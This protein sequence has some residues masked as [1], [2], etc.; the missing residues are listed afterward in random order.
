[1]ATESS[2]IIFNI[3]HAP[4]PKSFMVTIPMNMYRIK[5]YAFEPGLDFFQRSVLKLKANPRVTNTKIAECLGLDEELV[6]QIVRVLQY[7]NYVDSNGFLTQKG[8]ET[9]KNIDGLAIN[10]QE[11]QLGY[12]FQYIDRDDY[13]PYYIKDLGEAPNM[14]ND[15]D[16]IIGTKGDGRD[17]VRTP[18]PIDSMEKARRVLPFPNENVIIDLIMKS[19]HKDDIFEKKSARQMVESLSLSY[20]HETPEP[21]PVLFCTY[22]YLP[23]RDEDNLYEP[24]WQILDP[25]GHDDSS[26]L[27]FYIE[28]LNDPILNKEI[29]RK[30]HDAETLARKN[31]G[32]YNAFLTNEL[33]KMKEND[34]GIEFRALDRNLQQYLDSAIKNMFLFRQ[35]NY[36]DFDS[37]DM[38][39]IST[40]RALETLFRLDSERRPDVYEEMKDE[41]ST[42]EGGNREEYY[43][44]RRS[45]LND[46]IRN[47]LISIT[48]PGRLIGLSKKVEPNRANSLK[49]YIYSL[50]LTYN[51]DNHSPLFKLIDG[52]IEKLFDIAQLRNTKGHGQTEN[53]GTVQMVTKEV[54]EDTYTFLQD[55]INT[56]MHIAL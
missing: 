8:I 1:M 2:R 38:F 29:D 52:R 17:N 4:S 19:C 13:Y 5:T 45:F 35:Y 22:I 56:Y 46:L 36:H 48:D 47:R 53:E 20:F 31:F 43:R 49:Q 50:I 25:F 11:E 16:I 15:T 21:I 3:E 18:F 44:R 6:D 42:P 32:D 27:K 37:G 28:S 10:T 55:F 39:I 9:K 40:Q 7:N 30:F 24:E 12:V 33:Q 41:F 51:Y 34:F 54:A 26:Q 14:E 23:K